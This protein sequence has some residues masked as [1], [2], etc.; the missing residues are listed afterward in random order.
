MKKVVLFT[1]VALLATVTGFAQKGDGFKFSLGAELGTSS[2]SFSNTYS[3][4]LGAS[5]Q[6]EIPLQDKLNA[7]AYGG[8]L[9]YNG[10]T[11]VQGTKYKGATIIPV[12]VGVKYFLLDGIYGEFQTGLAFYNTSN[13]GATSTSSSFSFSPQVG[14]EFKTKSDKAI[15]ATLKYE[16]Y[17]SKIS[18]VGLRLAYIF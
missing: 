12:R 11:A 15:D 9:F 5:A 13:Y 1:V 7:V 17:S 2:G 16:V 6:V 14:Y 10:K 18:T 4:G 8:M 3:I